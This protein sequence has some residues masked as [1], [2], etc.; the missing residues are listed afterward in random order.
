MAKMDEAEASM[1]R[2]LEEKTG[3]SL[4]A[5]I[6]VARA[7]GLARHGELRD[8]LK[9]THAL[10]HGYANFVVH[11]ALGSDAG[12]SE[13][14]ALVAAQ[15]AG[16]KAALKPIYDQLIEAVRGFGPD[17]EIA[18]KKGYVSLRRS[19]QFALIQPSTASRMDVGLVLKGV[20]PSQRL[21]AAG[22]FNAMVTHR[23]RLEGPKDADTE[24]IAWLRRAY[25]AA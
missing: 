17:V 5:W 6:G 4:D 10:T 21:E 11:K 24:L 15:Y 14:D 12:S 18:P 16:A 19:K 8:H 13:P 7:S 1:A 22:S 23:V 25:D 3:K 20:P 9:N 2:T